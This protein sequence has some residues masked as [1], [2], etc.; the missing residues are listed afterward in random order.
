MQK[1]RV[2]GTTGTAIPHYLYDLSLPL[3]QRY[4]Q[5]LFFTSAI[6]A[7]TFLGV[8]P[9]RIYINRAKKHRIWSEAQGK[10]FAVRIAENQVAE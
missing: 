2:S 1:I 6:S 4:Q 8:S 9:Q 10:W 7:A 5:R 3:P